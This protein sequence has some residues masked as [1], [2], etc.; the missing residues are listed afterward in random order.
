MS[1]GENTKSEVA[2]NTGSR[3]KKFLTYLFVLCALAGI[4]C[5]ITYWVKP[6]VFENYT[7]SSTTS[8]PSTSSSTKIV[9]DEL[10]VSKENIVRDVP[11]TAPTTE[12]KSTQ[13]VQQPIIEGSG[14]KEGEL[15]FKDVAVPETLETRNSVVTKLNRMIKQTVI[16]EVAQSSCTA[17]TGEE[18]ADLLEG[19]TCSLVTL[20]PSVIY[21]MPREV[22]VAGHKAIIG[23][24]IKMPAI[25]ATGNRR[26]FTVEDGGSLSLKFLRMWRGSGE[27]VDVGKLQVPVLR[28]G[29]VFI[30]KG[31]FFGFGVLFTVRPPW[32]EPKEDAARRNLQDIIA[33]IVGVNIFGGQVYVGGGVANL[34][35]CHFLNWGKVGFWPALRVFGGDILQGGGVL[36]ANACTFVRVHDIVNA[37]VA[38][39]YTNV[40]VGAAVFNGCIWTLNVG[41]IQANGAG[42]FHFTGAGV[43]V[44]NGG[45]FNANLGLVDFFGAGLFQFLGAGA[46]IFN[47][48]VNSANLGVSA[49]AGAGTINFTGAGAVAYNGGII[50]AAFGV[51][52]LAG[53]GFGTYLGT[54]SLVMTGMVYSLTAGVISAYGA[55][56][57][58]NGSGVLVMVGGIISQQF[59]VASAAMAGFT[60]FMGAG[61]LVV[62]G[63]KQ[64]ISVAVGFLKLS[65]VIINMGAGHAIFRGYDLNPNV[66]GDLVYFDRPQNDPIL[67]V[68]GAGNCNGLGFPG[69]NRRQLASGPIES[70]A[71][72]DFGEYKALMSDNLPIQ[73]L[74][75]ED[76]V[77]PGKDSI[78]SC[79]AVNMSPIQVPAGCKNTVQESAVCAPMTT[80]SFVNYGGKSAAIAANFMPGNTGMNIKVSDVVDFKALA[81]DQYLVAGE[82]VTTCTSGPTCSSPTDI[83]KALVDLGMSNYATVSVG[84]KTNAVNTLASIAGGE[85]KANK[86]I[87]K[88]GEFVT[89]YEIALPTVAKIDAETLSSILSNSEALQTQL[90]ATTPTLCSASSTLET[91]IMVPTSGNVETNVDLATSP[92]VVIVTDA[93]RSTTFTDLRNGETHQFLF[94]DFPAGDRID[95]SLV[96]PGNNE[97]DQVMKLSSVKVNDLNQASYFWDIQ[98]VAQGTYYIKATSESSASIY[99]FSSAFTISN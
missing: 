80:E 91:D 84:S 70:T 24:P 4:A 75:F 9:N 77:C 30:N 57:I 72:L 89:S 33:N 48:V 67:V 78:R 8:S 97:M 31:S 98:D 19:N 83:A 59:A 92:S 81:L 13:T 87:S 14:V 56:T 10:N 85:Y 51:T 69:C 22:E 55:G 62:V 40:L 47:G 64:S 37:A 52:F 65:G 18:L 42:I 46:H 38:G 88:C 25:D 86:E 54:G 76:G 36:I 5:G 28:G 90:K 7:S 20:K 66:F 99:A 93:T 68:F 1:G 34:V 95:V 49:S 23:H 43:A 41:A 35:N 96:I 58:F 45:I 16:L 17:S 32:A 44:F 21:R 27:L 71:K 29:S 61:E 15:A 26:A 73:L 2:T 63:L 79:G 74:A 3:F 94:S 53:S 60:F 11:V 6:E 82:I 12:P 50:Q 39:V